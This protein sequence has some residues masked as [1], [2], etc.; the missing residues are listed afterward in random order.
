MAFWRNH[1]NETDIKGSVLTLSNFFFNHQQG[2]VALTSSA[3]SSS[4]TSSDGPGDPLPTEP[5]EVSNEER[6]GVDS[7][8]DHKHFIDLSPLIPKKPSRLPRSP[9]CSLGDAIFAQA[10]SL[11]IKSLFTMVCSKDVLSPL[12]ME[13]LLRSILLFA[14]Q[15]DNASHFLTLEEA[16]MR[17]TIIRR[18]IFQ[19][20]LGEGGRL[21]TDM[22]TTKDQDRKPQV[23]DMHV[24]SSLLNCPGCLARLPG[25]LRFSKEMRTDPLSRQYEMVSGLRS[26]YHACHILVLR[27]KITISQGK[28]VF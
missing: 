7:A 13:T 25:G 6:D 3:S 27:I 15:P 14:V 2:L 23:E 24:G 8:T 4:T 16:E 5:P 19:L 17:S 20:I 11:T 10:R 12:S 28:P 1:V 22:K 18:R 26:R 21:T 9:S